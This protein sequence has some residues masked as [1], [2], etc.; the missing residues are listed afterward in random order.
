MVAIFSLAQ[1]FGLSGPR[2]NSQ[3]LNPAIQRFPMKYN[4]GDGTS[5]ELGCI[6]GSISYVLLVQGKVLGVRG[7]LDSTSSL[8]IL[9][10]AQA[11]SLGPCIVTGCST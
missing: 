9:Y 1:T 2:T 10:A 5:E 3:A 6:D 4:D 7:L 11:R 8:H